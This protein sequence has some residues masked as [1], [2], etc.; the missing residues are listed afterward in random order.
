M[1]C[2]DETGSFTKKDKQPVMTS[3]AITDTGHASVPAVWQYLQMAEALG[4]ETAPCLAAAGIAVELL[5]DSNRRIP[6]PALERLLACLIPRSDDPCFGL[7][8]SAF[9]QPAS[10]SVLGYIAMNCA[11]V[12]EALAC[13]PL[14]EKIVGD[15]GITTVHSQGDNVR[16]EWHC[17]FT[18]PVVR[19]HVIENVL[20]SWTRYTRWMSGK[21]EESPLAVV[22]EHAAPADSALLEEYHNVF[23]AALHFDQPCSALIVS[24]R[25][26]A[27]P[28]RHADPQLLKTL[29]QHATAV[30]AM[31]DEHETVTLKV[32][33]LLRLQLHD[34]LPRKETIANQLNMTARTLQR[35]LS[36]ESTSFQALL[37]ELRQE[38]A[39]YYLLRTQL[40]VDEIGARLGFA[41]PRS[42]H[43][44][45]KQWTGRTP[46]QF[47]G[48]G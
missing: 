44:S 12:G 10:Y 15:M 8:T 26:L 42:F 18:D 28:I 13:I 34:T 47:R 27:H 46:G 33:N 29:L 38:L 21:D 1:H 24:A 6:G 40:S 48:H 43:R 4:M 9:I 23:G 39:E 31:I 11:T 45:F 16:V 14:Y 7:H 32:K 36:D 35:R 3:S 19:R 17:H 20:A 41:E 25:Q 37:N 2:R 5:Q 30:L 22:F